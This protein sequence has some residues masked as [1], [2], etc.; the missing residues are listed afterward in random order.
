M[1]SIWKWAKITLTYSEVLHVSS[2]TFPWWGIHIKRLDAYRDTCQ[3]CHVSKSWHRGRYTVMAL[4][5]NPSHTDNSL[6]ARVTFGCANG[7][8]SKQLER[9]YLKV[10]LCTLKRLARAS[11]PCRTTHNSCYQIS[12]SRIRDNLSREAAPLC[13]DGIIWLQVPAAHALMRER[14][15]E[16]IR[17]IPYHFQI[18]PKANEQLCMVNKRAHSCWWCYF[19]TCT[20]V[21][22]LHMFTLRYTMLQFITLL[23]YKLFLTASC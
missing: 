19:S 9:V 5:G 10:T 14:L 21:R 2:W 1:Y 18:Q 12:L 15:V 11:M 17:T 13:S 4:P 8:F 23:T 7:W 16:S 6:I 22:H 3:R 20:W